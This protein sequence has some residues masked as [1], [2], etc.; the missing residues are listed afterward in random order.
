M[1]EPL[2]FEQY[3][4]IQDWIPPRIVEENEFLEPKSLAARTIVQAGS[5][6]EEDDYHSMEDSDADSDD[7]ERHLTKKFEELAL[8]S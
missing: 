6:R 2:S 8:K 5:P 3:Q 7:I 1:G 4:N